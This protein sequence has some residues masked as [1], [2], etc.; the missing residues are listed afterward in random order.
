[1]STVRLEQGA[2]AGAE[3]HGVHTASSA[4]PTLPR[5]VRDLR[6]APPAP[7]NLVGRRRQRHGGGSG[8]PLVVYGDAA[9]G[10]GELL[11]ALDAAGVKAMCKVQP[12]VAQ[13]PRFRRWSRR[14]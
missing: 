4:F 11:Q 9:Y 7:P 1:M 2:L 13:S 10:A 5:P 6:W 12:P 3:R 8:R 14:W